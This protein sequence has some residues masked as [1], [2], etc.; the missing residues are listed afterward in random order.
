MAFGEDQEVT[1]GIFV[2]HT[3]VTQDAWEI[4]HTAYHLGLTIT[5]SL[6]HTAPY[7]TYT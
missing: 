3:D 5:L 7:P 2:A 6:Y 4:Y 1:S